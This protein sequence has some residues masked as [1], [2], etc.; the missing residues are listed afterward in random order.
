MAKCTWM[1]FCHYLV[2]M[3]LLVKGNLSTCM[4]SSI[5]LDV[6]L[7]LHFLIIS[8]LLNSN[9]CMHDGHVQ[10]IQEEYILLRASLLILCHIELF[11][12]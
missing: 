3:N 2:F 12:T 11:H 8:L 7:R 5:G 10:F 6:V 4:Y 1:R 9:M